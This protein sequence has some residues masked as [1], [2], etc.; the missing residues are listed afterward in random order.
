MRNLR[1]AVFLDKDG[2][3]IEDVPYNV[4]PVLVTLS[5]GAGQGL[6]R[7]AALGFRLL[8]VSNQPGLAMGRF[9]EAALHAAWRQLQRLAW[10]EGVRLEGFY[11]CPHHP[12]GGC[13][14]R[15]PEPG[16]LLDAA[17]EHDIDLAASW[18]IGDILNDIEAGRRAG[19]RTVL[20][21]N[22]HETEWERGPMR[23]PDLIA[24]DIDMAARMVGAVGPGWP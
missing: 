13:G 3:L 12:D 11:Y 23:T 18:M 8:V 9:G 21:D 6:R 4:D 5:P 2:T 20:I 16:L 17:R 24:P 7:L 14:C 19:C 1:P 22:G 10:D 15:K